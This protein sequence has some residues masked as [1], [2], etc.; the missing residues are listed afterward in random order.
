MLRT[1]RSIRIVFAAAT[2]AIVTMSLGGAAVMPRHAA[3]GSAAGAASALWKAGQD[4]LQGPHVPGWEFNAP[5]KVAS[6]GTHVW[7]AQ[8]RR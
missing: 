4:A 1:R 3:G 5:A 8:L 7:V 2:A 6:D